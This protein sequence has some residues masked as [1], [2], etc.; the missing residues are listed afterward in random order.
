MSEEPVP[1]T[2]EAMTPEGFAATM[3][4]SRETRARLEAYVDCLMVWQ[5]TMNLVGRSTLPDLWRRHV[6]DSAQLARLVPA[7]TTRLVD[8]GSGAG[9]PGMV[10]AILGVPG[11]ELVE[12][13]QRKAD[14]LQ[15]A[16]AA[17]GTSVVIHRCRAEELPQARA[18]VVTARAVAPLERLVP[19]AA[20]FMGEG[21]LAIL[22]KGSSLDDELK[23]VARHW[24]LWYTRHTSMTDPRGSILVIDRLYYDARI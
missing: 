2:P 19:L 21:S 4:V 9:F 6:L 5:E 15:A 8:L 13:D 7:Q 3:A 20:R 22:P 16:A 24:H 10:L 17:S 23:A 12:S 11:V 18:D 1:V 14:F